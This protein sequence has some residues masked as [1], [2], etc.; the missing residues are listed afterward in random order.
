MSDV[1]PDDVSQRAIEHVKA[2]R[3]MSG[4][5]DGLFRP[6][7]TVNR[8]ELLKALV[9]AHYKPDDLARCTPTR[10]E[11]FV[12]VS[13]DA[14]YA[15]SVCVAKRDG[16][17]TGFRGKTFRPTQQVSLAE[18]AS[19]IAAVY[20]I[21]RGADPGQPWYEPGIVALAERHAIPSSLPSHAAHVTRRE[22]AEILWRLSEGVIDA[23]SA[24]ASVVLAGKCSAL[25]ESIPA[26]D[27]EEI[28]RVWLAWTNDV[29]TGL[30]LPPYQEDLHL[31]YTALDWAK[32]AAN[33]GSISHKRPGQT[34]YYD[35]KR[36]ESWFRGYD[37]A[38][39]NEERTTFTESIGWGVYS[40]AS[41][42]CTDEFLEALRTSFEFFHSEKGKAY[43]P[44]YNSMVNPY[45][46]DV[47]IGVAAAKGKYFLTV[48]YATDITSQPQAVC[49]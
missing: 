31:T 19:M 16:V 38:F 30:G 49:R 17:I 35:Y 9:A 24:T 43:A 1:L 48:H 44:H 25:D 13:A 32:A 42:D 47:G 41:S 22:V 12:D 20:E 37:L 23:P 5:S 33:R 46:R 18:A 15:A 39:A 14:W 8:A 4:Y 26:V 34:A 11:R 3:I 29:R 27:T 28:R 45:F 2:K 40:C 10:E 21:E 7:R 6:D 36:M